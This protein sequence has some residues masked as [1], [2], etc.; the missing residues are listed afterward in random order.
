MLFSTPETN[1]TVADL[2]FQSLSPQ[3][4]ILRVA[5]GS[6]WLKETM[7]E[8]NT[9]LVFAETATVDEQSQG[10]F[11]TIHLAEESI[12]VPGTPAG[13]PDVSVRKQMS[14]AGV[15]SLV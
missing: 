1:L 6:G 14:A 12:S 10:G 13:S 9:A 8:L 11:V 4:I 7:K 2:L 3:M 15:I 5:M